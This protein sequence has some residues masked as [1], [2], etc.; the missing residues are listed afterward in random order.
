MFIET[1]GAEETRL[2]AEI[3]GKHLAPQ[4]LILFYGDL[5]AGKTL[6]TQGIGKALG[7]ARM[8]SPSFIIASEY[9]DTTPPLLHVD[10]YRLATEREID[11]L[12]IE[13]YLADGFAVCVEWSEN[14][15]NVPQDHIKIEIKKTGETTRC[16][17]CSA[18]GEKHKKILQ[19]IKEELA[20]DYIIH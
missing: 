13:D 10:L 15:Q 5:G 12:E 3:F 16:I 9:P 17:T 11:S 1:R 4:T 7:I 8:K 20:N 14:W 19:D 2:I 6:F 18:C